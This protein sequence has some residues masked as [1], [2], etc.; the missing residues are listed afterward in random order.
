[1]ID[2]QVTLAAAATEIDYWRDGLTLEAM[3][4]AGLSRREL[5]ERVADGF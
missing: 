5:L 4:V 3:G 2:A 1:M